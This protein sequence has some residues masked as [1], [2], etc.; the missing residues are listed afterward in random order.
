MVKTILHNLYVDHCLTSV[1]TEEEAL[2]LYHDLRA[3]CCEGGFLLTKWISNSRHVLAVIPEEHRAKEVKDLDHDQLPVERMLGVK[4]CVQSDTFKFKITF[5]DR[6]P[7][8]RGI[9][10]TVRAAN[11][12]ATSRLFGPIAI[13]Y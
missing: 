5:Q 2:S 6:P 13:L 7:P 3:I 1:A 4:W 11:A 8:R 12:N 10:S 9:L